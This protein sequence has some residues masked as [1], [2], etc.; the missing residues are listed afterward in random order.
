MTG[1]SGLGK[2]AEAGG[3]TMGR[4]LTSSAGLALACLLAAGTISAGAAVEIGD[5]ADKA[6]GMWRH[7]ENGSHIELYK[8]GEGLC[9]KLAKLEDG[10]KTD[11]KNP[12]PALR[13]RPLAGLV[14]MN[15]AKKTAS[16]MWSGAIYS[17]ADGYTYAGTITVRTGDLLDLKG[18]TMAVFCKTVT[19]TRVQEAAGVVPAM[20]Q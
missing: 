12:N 9:A 3:M 5:K 8:C 2:Q 15:G 16:N 17:R 10:Q 14:I 18:C 4:V 19:W 20:K 6:F 1:K 13:T 11:D 7:P